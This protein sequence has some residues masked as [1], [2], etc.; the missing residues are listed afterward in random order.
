[1]AL[2]GRSWWDRAKLALGATGAE[3]AF[4]E[5]VQAWLDAHPL[6]GVDGPDFLAQCLAQLHAAR[7]AGLL[8]KDRILAGSQARVKGDLSR[9]GDPG[10]AVEV[11]REALAGISAILRR[12][13]YEALAAF[14]EL[15]PAGGPPVLMASLRFF[16]QREVEADRELF[17]GLAYARLDAL[18]AGQRAGFAGLGEALDAHAERLEGML[19]DIRSVVE[20]THGDVLDIKAELK[21]Q[22]AQAQEVGAL[23]LKALSARQLERR[24][25]HGGDSLSIRDDDERRLVRDLVRRYRALP[26]EQRKDAPAL[27]NAVGK[28]QVVAGEYEAAEGDFRAAAAMTGDPSARAEIAHNAYLAALERRAWGDALSSLK[29]AAEGDPARFAPFPLAKLSPERIL[30]AGG[31]GVAFLCRNRHSGGQV[32]VKTLRREG[33]ERGLEEVFREA[34]AME[35]LDHPAIIRIRDCDC[36]DQGRQRPYVVMDYFAPGQT[37]DD[38]VEQGGPLRHEEA[39]PLLKLVASGLER[40]HERGIL[41]RDIKPGNVL[42]RRG[43]PGR[44]C[45]LID[46]G[47]A[48]RSGQAGSTARSHL[49]KTLTGSS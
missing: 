20:R 41:H 49:D 26:A 37:L 23:I 34:E 9:F 39:L 8:K 27:L 29:E 46:F 21:R 5:Q 47:L 19:S 6:D 22:G 32:G 30:G 1:M 15:W 44:E 33:L 25:P 48:L 18:E 13:G 31:F 10:R 12:E 38:L 17:Q 40:A 28:L 7:K 42:V 3:R 43:A 14:L 16:F 36:A 11:E 35:G 45:K 2:A 4:R 24:E